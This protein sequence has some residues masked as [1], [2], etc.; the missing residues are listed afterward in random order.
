MNHNKTD[1]SMFCTG[2]FSPASFRC[3]QPIQVLD[4]DSVPHCVWVCVCVCVCVHTHFV[5]EQEK[6][7]M[8]VLEGGEV[9]FCALGLSSS[10]QYRFFLHWLLCRPVENSIADIT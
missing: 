6:K 4:N 10:L 7:D 8:E 2:L 1:V 3:S 9:F 5:E